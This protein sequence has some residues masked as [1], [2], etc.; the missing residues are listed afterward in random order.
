MGCNSTLRK[1]PYYLE[2]LVAERNS[3]RAKEQQTGHNR[4]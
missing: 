3:A 4:V 2:N 1:L